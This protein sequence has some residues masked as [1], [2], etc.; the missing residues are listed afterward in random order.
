MLS[1]VAE[2]VYWMGRYIERVENTARLLN[3][4]SA[5]LFD[6]PRG[7][8]IGWNTLVDI[9]G[10]NEEFS[11]RYSS[12][13]E[14]SVVRFLLTDGGS[15]TSIFCGL[16]MVRE[17]ARTT[18]E[19]IPSECWEHINDLYHF[20]RE[21]VS[22]GVSRGRRHELLFQII[23]ECQQISGLLSD[24]MSHN[25]AYAFI[26]IGRKLE[27]A[28]MTTRIV[29]VGSINLLPGMKSDHEH[30]ERL[31]AYENVIWM[32]ILRSLSAYQAYRQHVHNRVSGDQVVRYLL[33]DSE[34]P[35][36]VMFCLDQ[37]NFY[38]GKLPN[39]ENVLRAVARVQRLSKDV[40]IDDLLEKGLLD[41]IDELQIS[42][43]DIHEELR[44]SWF[45]P[46]V[47]Q[48]QEQKAG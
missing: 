25:T 28:D 9:T 3:V 39:H 2:R 13:D 19:V 27:R 5:M 48:Q 40:K 20:A 17:N 42:I 46:A 12:M 31:A 35:R 45:R 41:F 43:A 44:N 21:N 24:T 30:S 6:L 16:K 10:I 8:D 26:N 7:T 18:R 1:S 22:S 15:P 37:L 23:A 47:T 4:Y 34:F 33:Q 29:D 38:I 11:Q 14:K 32:C 36:S